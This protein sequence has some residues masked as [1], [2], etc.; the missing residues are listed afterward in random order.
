MFD[1]IC[2]FSLSTTCFQDIA[3]GSLNDAGYGSLEPRHDTDRLD[4]ARTRVAAQMLRSRWRRRPYTVERGAL[5]CSV[6]I[7]SSATNWSSKPR[8]T[9]SVASSIWVKSIDMPAAAMEMGSCRTPS[10][11]LAVVVGSM[12]A[13]SEGLPPGSFGGA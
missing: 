1:E 4:A 13:L 2:T 3:D 7:S 12:C 11:R 5:G 8:R 10:M 9:A 6:W